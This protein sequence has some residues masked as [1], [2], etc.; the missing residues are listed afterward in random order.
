[1]GMIICI[2]Y[3]QMSAISQRNYSVTFLFSPPRFVIEKKVK[4]TRNINIQM[5]VCSITK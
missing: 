1:M 3:S 2:E 4:V 5:M